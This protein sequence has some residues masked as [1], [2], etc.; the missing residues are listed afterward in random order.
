MN[1]PTSWNPKRAP[2]DEISKFPTVTSFT[3]A[4]S[5]SSQTSGLKQLKN[6]SGIKSPRDVHSHASS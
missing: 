3:R 1:L 5:M 6:N 2:S 4:E